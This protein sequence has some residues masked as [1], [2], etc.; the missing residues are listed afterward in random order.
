MPAVR[1]WNNYNSE[2]FKNQSYFLASF[3]V[4][5]YSFFLQ[6]IGGGHKK[7]SPGKKLHQPPTPLPFPPS[8]KWRVPH[9][10]CQTAAKKKL[11]LVCVRFFFVLLINDSHQHVTSL[12]LLRMT[13]SFT[14]VIPKGIYFELQI[15]IC[16]SEF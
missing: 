8:Y 4:E 10:I 15:I 12:Y 11:E 7:I 9:M 13:Y 6:E 16:F 14:T 1:T 2:V 3:C 5:G